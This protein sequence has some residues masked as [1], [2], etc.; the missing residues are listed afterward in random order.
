MSGTERIGTFT[1][2]GLVFDVR[3]EGPIDGTPV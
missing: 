1:R 3:D 2:D